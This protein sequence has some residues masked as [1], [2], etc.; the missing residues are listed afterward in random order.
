MLPAHTPEI[1]W[2]KFP[3]SFLIRRGRMSLPKFQNTLILPKG[4]LAKSH[5]EHIQDLAVTRTQF[6]CDAADA[7][8]QSA[9]RKVAAKCH[10]DK[11]GDP[12]H[13]KELHAARDEW[14]KGHER[15]EAI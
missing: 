12:E 7:Q 4:I 3:G 15:S 1:G 9:F 10:P 14:K 5:S 8:V 6:N 2:I 11:G 13:A